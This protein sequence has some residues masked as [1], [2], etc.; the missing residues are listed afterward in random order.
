MLNAVSTQFLDEYCQAVAKAGGVVDAS[1]Q[2]NITPVME[3]KLRQAIVESD[4]FLNRISN[5][6]VDQIKGQVIDVG[7]S[8]L[9]TGRVKD[10][11][12]MGSL[13]QSGNTYEL[14]ETDSGAHINWITMTIWANSGGKGQWMKLMN[15]AITRNF[16]LDKL[17]IGFHGT[18]IA[19]EST[20]P[21]ANPMGE[22]VNKGWL[23][24]AKEKAPAQVLPAV[25]LDSTGATEG[26]Y[27]NLDS[28][29]N[30]L[31]NTT[32]HE[33][34]QGDP[35]LVVLI[36]RNL[37][38]AEQHRL[39]ESAEVPTEHKAAQSLAK[40]VAGKT[41][42][43]PPFFPPDMIWVTN[44]SNLQILTQKGTQ[45]RKSRNE[46]D[47]KRFETSYLR[48]EGYAV[49]NYHK[50]AAIEEVTVIVPAAG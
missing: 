23:Q 30:D 15:N 33:V 36:G 17:R 20:D 8:G 42:Y 39:L 47:R 25:K 44:L 16:A 26:S 1:K 14:T 50:F 27:R 29:V 18:S 46:E 22:D 4:S 43:T 6:S 3:T 12:F 40:T 49:G 7:D 2:F 38:A 24:L 28:L 35:D 41:V 10:G 32:I 13:D 21:K 9:L 34:H 5:I 11:R 37:V 31:I 48:M 45:W 19:G